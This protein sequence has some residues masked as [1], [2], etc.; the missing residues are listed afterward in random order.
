M[1]KDKTIQEVVISMTQSQRNAL[2]AIVGIEVGD[3]LGENE[4]AYRKIVN[5]MNEEQKKALDI[6]V[7][8]AKRS[9]NDER[10]SLRSLV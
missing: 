8:W 6:I 5:T 4:K 10:S 3:D 9:R 2:Y 1:N 7:D